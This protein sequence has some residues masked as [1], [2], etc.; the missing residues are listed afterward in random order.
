VVVTDKKIQH[1]VACSSSHGFN[2]LISW[3]WDTGVANGN[4]IEGLE[5]V[6]EAQ[7]ATLLFDTEPAG[8][9][10]RIGVLINSRSKF[11]F[12]NLDNVA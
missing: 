6:D 3:W 4:S 5:I 8:A 2:D 12:E 11:V 7:S 9:V 1:G 10:G